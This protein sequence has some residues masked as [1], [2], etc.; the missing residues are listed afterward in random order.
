MSKK[1]KALD[2]YR[3]FCNGKIKAVGFDKE[4]AKMHDRI[5]RAGDHCVHVEQAHELD[6]EIYYKEVKFK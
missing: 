2:S 1:L 4:A 3:I 5:L 6:F